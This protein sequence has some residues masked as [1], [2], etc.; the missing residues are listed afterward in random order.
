[1]AVNPY[2]RLGIEPNG[3]T[4]YSLNE[5]YVI[6]PDEFKTKG[7]STLYAGERAFGKCLATVC[8]GKLIYIDDKIIKR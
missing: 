5:E 2:K 3:F 6:N 7:R 4:V 8:D 1:M